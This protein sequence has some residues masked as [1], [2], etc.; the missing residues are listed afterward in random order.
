[1]RGVRFQSPVVR[2]QSTLGHRQR[3]R[4][5]QRLRLHWR[6]N[7]ERLFQRVQRLRQAGRFANDDRFHFEIGHFDL[8]R[9]RFADCRRWDFPGWIDVIVVVIVIV[10]AEGLRRHRLVMLTFVFATF[11]ATILEPDLKL[12]NLK[13]ILLYISQ[14]IFVVIVLFDGFLFD[15]F[16]M[17]L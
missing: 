7:F 8:V 13:L 11:C 12:K 3:H 2:R 6:L 16:Q 17:T 4:L 1:M 9:R 15:F 5:H 10:V 14:L